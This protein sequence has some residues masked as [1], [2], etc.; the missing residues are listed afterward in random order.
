MFILTLQFVIKSGSLSAGIN[1]II[2][3]FQKR[4]FSNNSFTN[5]E[6][7]NESLSSS[8]YEVIATYFKGTAISFRG[9]FPN[10]KHSITTITYL[11]LTVLFVICSFILLFISLKKKSSRRQYIALFVFLVSSILAP[12]SWLIIF[13]GHSYIH[14]SMNKLIW[15]MPFILIGAISFGQIMKYLVD[16]L[17]TYY[18]TSFT[19]IFKQ[20]HHISKNS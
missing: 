4:T 12:L 8:L 18:N 1:H 17:K 19:P 10:I 7:I 9:I 16:L 11:E 14:T 5:S 2:F 13:K 3:S 15:Y 6:V 20:R